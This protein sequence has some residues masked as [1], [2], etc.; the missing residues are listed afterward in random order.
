[1]L[2]WLRQNPAAFDRTWTVFRQ[3]LAMPYPG[4]GMIGPKTLSA[5]CPRPA[6][7]LQRRQSEY[8]SS[9]TIQRVP[10]FVLR[11]PSCVVRSLL[12]QALQAQTPWRATTS[13]QRL[14]LLLPRSAGGCRRGRNFGFGENGQWTDS[15]HVSVLQQWGRVWGSGVGPSLADIA[16]S[17]TKARQIWH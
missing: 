6:C 10:N 15:V 2:G 5:S 8:R 4:A 12:R 7:P 9:L 16:P 3:R 17:L 1:M 14:T 11:G 13:I